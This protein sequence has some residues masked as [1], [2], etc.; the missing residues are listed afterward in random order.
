LPGGSHGANLIKKILPDANVIS[1]LGVFMIAHE[2]MD[3]RIMPEVYK[4]HGPI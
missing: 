1:D 3:G 2:K 4:V